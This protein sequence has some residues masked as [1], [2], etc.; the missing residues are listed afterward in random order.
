M[1]V[2][3][4]TGHHINISLVGLVSDVKSKGDIVKNIT[5]RMIKIYNLDRLCFMGYTLDK[6]ASFHHIV[7]RCDGGKETIENGAV[8][9]KYAHEYLHIIEYKDI[10]TYIAINK[11]LK[12]INEQRE[13]P[14]PEQLQVISK[15]LSMFE[16]EHKEDKTSKGKQLI[17]YP[18]LDR[19][20]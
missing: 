7:K 11:I 1:G 15:M 2:K 20:Y 5:K 16:E 12:I 19:Y 3:R 8:L 4:E 10:D 14:T 18:Y 6:T 17:K 9:N 13:A